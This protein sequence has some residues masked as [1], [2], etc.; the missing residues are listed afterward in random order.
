ML[1]YRTFARPHYAK[2]DA[3]QHVFLGKMGRPLT[4]G[5]VEQM[6]YDLGK[7][8]GIPRLHPHLLRHTSATQYLVHGGDVISLQRKLGHSGLEMTSRYVHFAA[9]QMA[10]NCGWAP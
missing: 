6:A 9:D 3:V 10:A 7:A 4:P 1:L 8:V 2:D 5:A